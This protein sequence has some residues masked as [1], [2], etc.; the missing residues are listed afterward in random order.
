MHAPSRV[1]L[2]RVL[3]AL[4]P[5]FL[6]LVAGDVSRANDLADVAIYDEVEASMLPARG[7]V[8]GLGA[9]SADEVNALLRTLGERGASALIVRA[10]VPTTRVT[11]LV[12]RSAGVVLL[13][14]SVEASWTQ[15]ASM[16][17]TLL[18]EADAPRQD[19][20]IGGLPSGDLFAL[21]GAISAL[22]GAP[23]TI[24]D[25]EL[26]VLAFS[27]QQSGTDASRIE[28]ILGRQVPRRFA[29]ALDR[30]GVL[31]KLYSA[32]E[33]VFMTPDEL[34]SDE[35][36]KSRMAVAVR[37]GDEVLGSIWVVVDEPLADEQALALAD[38][39]KVVSLHML[40]LRAGADVERRVRIDQVADAIE[41]GPK[42]AEALS[43]LG[44]LGR[45][46]I[47]LAVGVLAESLDVTTASA[48]MAARHR[49][50]DA[51]ALY[52]SA[53]A[54]GS[55]VALLGDVTYCLWPVAGSHDDPTERLSR[56]LTD[57]LS[58]TST[59]APAV[60]GVGPVARDTSQLA[61]SKRGADRAL[62][63]L[64]SKGAAG[65]IATISDVLVDALLLELSDIATAQGDR[66]SGRLALL[67]AYDQEH[68]SQ[69]VHTLRC[70]L[71]SFGDITSA[72]AM[73]FVHANTFRYRLKRLVQVSGINLSDP[74][75]RFSAM[76]QFR[77]LCD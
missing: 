54:P 21:A 68:N 30:A 29:E 69:L 38:A 64:V 72:S 59:K 62:R 16:L 55:A 46:L 43:R 8:F 28:S 74:E 37:A 31:P 4:G 7:I 33:P 71:D 24:E 47:V 58:R 20:A 56:V 41:G 17:R 60:M 51:L 67:A 39:A 1:G 6:E 77:L 65:R 10:P 61:G 15:L 34:G 73:A 9:R 32:C 14:L 22:V 75:E 36:T 40:R 3:E 48:S 18:R 52:M 23:V 70:W 27:E 76:L 63:V 50:S 45:P 53:F 57:F 19:T 66:L 2:A 42:S 35:V 26:N 25:K 13:A 11:E 5:T 49:L 12:A 44:L